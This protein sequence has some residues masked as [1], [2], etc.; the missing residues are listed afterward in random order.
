LNHR[1]PSFKRNRFL[2]VTAALL[3]VAYGQAQVVDTYQKQLNE[4]IDRLEAFG[5]SGQ[6]L[7]AE[8]G[9]VILDKAYGIADKPRR[10]RVTSHTVFNI[11]SLSKQFTA[12]AVL[13]LEM[14]GKLKVGDRIGKY[15][16]EVP[17]D[18]SEIT[19][20]HLL[21]H[22]SGL[23]RDVI[24]P[25]EPNPVSKEGF[26][27]KILESQMGFKVG[28]RYAYSN[29]GY[30][31]LAA[32]IERVSS[33]TYQDY[34]NQHIFQLAGM[35]NTGSYQN[36][37]WQ[38]A[39]IAHGY[40]EWKE[41]GTFLS[42]PKGWNHTGSGG[43]V[44]TTGDLYRWFVVLQGEKILSSKQ[45]E[46]LFAKHTATPDSTTYYGY[47]WYVKS[48]AD[49]RE[50]IF[51]GG[52]NEG[53][54]SEFRWYPAEDRVI[55]IL[56][57]Q[58]IFGIDGGAVQKRIM[59]NNIVR[60]LSREKY[61]EPPQ[62]VKSGTVSLDKYVGDYEGPGAKFKI[63]LDG[64]HLK[65]GAEGQEAVNALLASD[66][67][68]GRLYASLNR[69]AEMVLKAVSEGKDSTVRKMLSEEEFGFYIPF[70]KEE[71]HSMEE[72]LGSFKGLVLPGTRPLPWDV[73]SLRTYAILQFEKGTSD[74]FLGWGDGKLNDV[75]TEE[76]RPFP[77]MLPLAPQSAK[78][79]TSFDPIT[80]MTV[81]VIFLFDANS[82][83]SGLMIRHEGEKV[84][85]LKR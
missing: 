24:R 40:D 85:A 66:D 60:I 18:K 25:A 59:A 23:R 33:Q 70:L 81:S 51:H 32:I 30:Q 13:R 11:A 71:L 6:V 16:E 47:G 57:N 20:H 22:T 14:D 5:L 12:E 83:V 46:K 2:F 1:Y 31:L 74:L 80:S 41:T 73:K 63:W 56:T 55:I 43:L 67:S 8:K 58:D 62:I 34:L 48:F 68:T 21:T 28:G 26:V 15:F 53:Y 65:M 82:R 76:G 10:L 75:T 29:A 84:I 4:Y 72:R 54:H 77:V 78:N 69:R 19:I 50:L 3:C 17:E 39:N 44:S 64:E 35:T 61:V 79:F 27:K 9:K 52:D 42:K 38:N 37:R 45:K 49:G 36:A 7:V